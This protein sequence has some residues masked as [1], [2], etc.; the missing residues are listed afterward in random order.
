MRFKLFVNE[1]SLVK[2]TT[3]R[4]KFEARTESLCHFISTEVWF[5]NG[6]AVDFISVARKFVFVGCQDRL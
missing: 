1:S 3:L 5:L 6:F 4:F 2:L